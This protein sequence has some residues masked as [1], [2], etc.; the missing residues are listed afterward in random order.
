MIN[1]F[2]DKVVF[3]V[4]GE[5]RGAKFVIDF[6]AEFDYTKFKIIEDGFATPI[7]A[8]IDEEKLF[9]TS[10]V[11]LVKSDSK[12]IYGADG[13]SQTIATAFAA[14]EMVLKCGDA[15]NYEDSAE[16]QTYIEFDCSG[17]KFKLLPRGI[18]DATLNNQRIDGQ[19]EKEWHGASNT[20][21]WTSTK[22]SN[23][24]DNNP[25]LIDEFYF[26][27]PNG[28]KVKFGDGNQKE[29]IVDKKLKEI[30]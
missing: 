19:D 6:V 14:G 2:H 29:H 30:I 7:Q 23:V 21:L 24:G 15:Q 5:G 22:M 4:E 13:Y 16:N 10:H 11:M 17:T 3:R 9:D 1:A 12:P 27:K 18:E 28:D 8:E 20:F 25:S 26:V